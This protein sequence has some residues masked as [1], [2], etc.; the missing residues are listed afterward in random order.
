MTR[1]AGTRG[2]SR[3]DFLSATSALGA[4]AA[5]GFPAIARAEPLPE[6]RKIRLARTASICLS[7]QYVAE[8]LLH[9][10]GFTEVEYPEIPYTGGDELTTGR[11]DLTMDYVPALVWKLDAVQA[12]SLCPASIPGATRLSPASRS[13][14]S[15]I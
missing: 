13:R 7:P 15:A 6:V 10:E 1:G 3:R 11:A 9:L 4:G 5:L 12:S 14:P 8:E 2:S